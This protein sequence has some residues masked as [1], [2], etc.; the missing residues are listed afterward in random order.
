[1]LRVAVRAVATT[2]SGS[3]WRRGRCRCNCNQQDRQNQGSAEHALRIGGSGAPPRA[4]RTPAIDPLYSRLMETP[5]KPRPLSSVAPLPLSPS[6]SASPSWP[7]ASCSCSTQL[8][9]SNEERFQHA[10]LCYRDTRARAGQ[11][12]LRYESSSSRSSRPSFGGASSEPYRR[13]SSNGRSH[14]SSRS[15]PSG[16]LR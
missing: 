14:A 10:V 7:S 12:H 6:R 13:H 5:V 9:I 16:S 4:A 2:S 1:M 11:R 15:F 3:G 8:A